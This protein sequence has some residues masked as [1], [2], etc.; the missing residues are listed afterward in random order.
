MK[1]TGKGPAL[2]INEPNRGGT[3][4][5]NAWKMRIEA[6]TA[7]PPRIR[8]FKPLKGYVLPRE[9]ERRKYAELPSQYAP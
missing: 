5:T 6:Q 4:E 7:A 3:N 8:E 2:S 1:R 9:D